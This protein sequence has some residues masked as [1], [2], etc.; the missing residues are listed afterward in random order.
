MLNERTKH[1]QIWRH[2]NDFG[3]NDQR[4]CLDTFKKIVSESLCDD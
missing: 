2:E 1:N 4:I 3:D